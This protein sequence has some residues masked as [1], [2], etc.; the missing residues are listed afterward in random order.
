MLHSHQHQHHHPHPLTQRYRLA[1]AQHRYSM[2]TYTT[3]YY[4]ESLNVDYSSIILES[5]NTM[6]GGFSDVNT[7]LFAV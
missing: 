3:N 4:V 6:E 5:T 1:T 7:L 2:F